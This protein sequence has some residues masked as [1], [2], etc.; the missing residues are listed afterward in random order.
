MHNLQRALDV[1]FQEELMEGDNAYHCDKVDA[2]VPA[3]KRTLLEKLPHTFVVQLKRFEFDFANGLRL[4]IQDRFEFPTNLDLRKYTEAA[5][6]EPASAQLPTYYEYELKGIVVHTGNAFAGH[7]FSFVKERGAH[8]KWLCMDDTSVT[9]WNPELIDEC[10][11]GGAA[12][13][14]QVRPNSAYMLVYERQDKLEPID[15]DADLQAVVAGQQ[16]ICVD[17]STQGGSAQAASKAA[18]AAACQL[19]QG[20]NDAEGDTKASSQQNTNLQGGGAADQHL[21]QQFVQHALVP[22]GLPAVL[23]AEVMQQNMLMAHASHWTSQHH[24]LFLKDIIA[25]CL[26]ISQSSAGHCQRLRRSIASGSNSGLK[27]MSCESR[28]TTPSKR[29]A[30]DRGL[31]TVPI[32]LT[33]NSTAGESKEELATQLS[34]KYCLSVLNYLPDLDDDLLSFFLDSAL[35]GMRSFAIES[36]VDL[37]YDNLLWR[38]P[39]VANSQFYNSECCALHPDR[40]LR[41]MFS[42]SLVRVVQATVPE[43]SRGGNVCCKG[44]NTRPLLLKVCSCHCYQCCTVVRNLPTFEPAI[45]MVLQSTISMAEFRASY[46]GACMLILLQPD[47]ASSTVATSKRILLLR[48][49][50]ICTGISASGL[51]LEHFQGLLHHQDGHV[52]R[53]LNGGNG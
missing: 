40:K 7:Y 29:F 23:Y 15:V 28:E 31:G 43:L 8:G 2:K 53:L 37:V 19:S 45:A 18:A 38:L 44:P 41:H 52:G 4:K 17:G 12:P 22:Y 27:S 32:P 11:F 35:E 25:D 33:L 49:C 24:M 51:G 42:D 46:Q 39:A 30:A 3:I 48:S 47:L 6:S 50:G 13:G 26:D 9:L 34:L 14:G 20:D 36:C 10:C 21:A 1:Y 5:H 16:M